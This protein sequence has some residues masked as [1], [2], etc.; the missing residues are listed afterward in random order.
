MPFKAYGSTPTISQPNPKISTYTT[1]KKQFELT[2]HQGN[3]LATI[4]DN[5]WVRNYA[6][7]SPVEGFEADWIY[8]TKLP[9]LQ[10]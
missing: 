3:V 9:P 6:G 5:V 7:S 2:N 10:E 1:G 4:S 8:R